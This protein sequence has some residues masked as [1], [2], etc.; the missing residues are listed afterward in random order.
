VLS[1]RQPPPQLILS[2]LLRLF[3][4]GALAIDAYVHADLAHRYDPNR[5]A[6]FSQGDLFRIEAG[7]SALAALA[8]LLTARRIAWMVAFAV[9]ASALGAILLYRYNDIGPLGPLPDMYEPLWYPEK[10]LAASAEAAAT[11]TGLVGFAMA[12]TAHIWRKYRPTT[13]AITSDGNPNPTNG[14]LQR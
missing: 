4:G 13:N 5:L 7:I 6:T 11:V 10:T 12:S 3:T 1:P 8:L 9:A 14:N 2:W